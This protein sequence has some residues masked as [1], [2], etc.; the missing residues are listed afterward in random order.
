MGKCRLLAGDEVTTGLDSQTAF[1]ITRAFKLFAQ[2]LNDTVVLSLLQPPPESFALFDKVIVLD[3]GAIAYHGPMEKITAH[4]ASI[5]LQLPRRKDV[6]DFLVEITSS[7]ELRAEYCSLSDGQ[8]PPSDL[9]AKYVEVC[10]S[11]TE[12]GTRLDEKY[13][14]DTSWGEYYSKEFTEPVSYYMKLCL[15][16]NLVVTKMN[17]AYMQTKFGQA[18]IMGIFTGTLYYQ[19]DYDEYTSK[20]GL[21]FSSLMYL[22]LSG[23]AAMPGLIER[24]AV[25]YKQRSASF[26]P[27]YAF[28]LSQV[29]IDVVVTLLETIVYANLVYWPAGLSSSAFFPFFVLC[30]L[31][32]LAMSQWFA[33]VAAAAPD[34]QAAQ[35]AAGMS[36]VLCVLFSG[37]IVQ[38]ENVPEAWKPLYW[39]SPVALAWRAAS[40]NE[41]RS[42]RYDKCTYQISEVGCPEEDGCCRE[43]DDGI[44]FLK[45]YSLQTESFFIQVGI[46]VLF[47][48]FLLSVGLQTLVL[49]LVHYEGHGAAPPVAEDD[50]QDAEDS[51]VRANLPIKGAVADQPSSS[52]S[53]ADIP[54][55]PT[56]IAFRDVH[57]SVTVPSTNPNGTAEQ[58][59]LLGGVTGFAKPS[60]MTALMGSRYIVPLAESSYAEYRRLVCVSQRCR[61]NCR[62]RSLGHRAVAKTQI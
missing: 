55:A 51:Y 45:T 5:G 6:A 10:P 31:L 58:L 18:F 46:I 17:P 1:E 48:Y 57:Y 9:H 3:K 62:S 21:L 59:E 28:T 56:T 26:F 35:P 12:M 43:N 25:F 38:R 13:T 20:F 19:I 22:G 37:F 15:N 16:R 30:F 34:S 24:R 33:V 32:S 54:Y 39:V 49:N 11:Y 50:L 61:E 27:T 42:D 8:K 14:A 7:A 4:F 52:H 23:M 40:I 44:Y 47:A 36:I 60:T 2:H 53:S 29:V 41:F